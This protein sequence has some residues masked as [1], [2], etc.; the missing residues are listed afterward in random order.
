MTENAVR[1]NYGAD[2]WEVPVT[3]A[4]RLVAADVMIVGVAVL[5]GVA[6]GVALAVAQSEEQNLESGV[7]RATSE[8]APRPPRCADGTDRGP[9]RMGAH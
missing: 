6:A 4:G 7:G 3:A 1:W 8:G 5:G 2:G 9:S